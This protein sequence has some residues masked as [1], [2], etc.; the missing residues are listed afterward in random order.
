MGS[1]DF[2]DLAEFLRL[3]LEGFVDEPEVGQEDSMSFEDGGDVHGSWVAV[4]A[5]LRPVDIIVGVD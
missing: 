2:D 3:L 1:P 4:V 5:G